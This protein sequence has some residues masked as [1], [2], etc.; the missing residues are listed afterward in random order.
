MNTVHLKISKWTIYI[1]FNVIS[2]LINTICKHQSY[3]CRNTFD[4]TTDDH[5]KYIHKLY[6]YSYA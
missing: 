5:T 2:I 1:I 3:D 4:Y 6:V